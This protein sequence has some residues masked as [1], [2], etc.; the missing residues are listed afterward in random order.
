M[1]GDHKDQRRKGPAP[2]AQDLTEAEEERYKRARLRVIGL[3]LEF[4]FTTI[5]SFGICLFAGIWLDRRFGTS[6][7][8]LLLGL[9][10]AFVAVGYNLYQLATV[11][12]VTRP[13]TKA[14][15]SSEQNKQ[16]K[17]PVSNWDDLD[18]RD[19]DDDWPKRPKTG[20]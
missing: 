1:G 12:L 10:L 15:A 18:E 9:L 5:G 8:L 16:T 13:S 20:G 3:A 7:F 19:E 17:R 2:T 11:K 4:G 14:A 6:P